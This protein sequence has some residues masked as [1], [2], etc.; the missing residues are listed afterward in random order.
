LKGG[1]VLDRSTKEKI[2]A[3]LHEKLLRAKIAILAD[4]RGI[5]VKELNELRGELR[6][7]DSEVRV[8]K[9]NILN[10]ALKETKFT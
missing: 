6:K 2:V 5:K 9:N 8:V 1:H 10:L 4:Y 7:S 3:E